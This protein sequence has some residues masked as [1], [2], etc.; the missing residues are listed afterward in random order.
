MLKFISSTDPLTASSYI[1]E[2]ID[3]V[4]YR[5]NRM[6]KTEIKIMASVESWADRRKNL[7]PIAC[8]PTA[9]SV[10]E[11]DVIL[12]RTVKYRREFGVCNNAFVS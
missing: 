6:Q 4:E 7:I 12:C 11:K 5:R 8:R 3:F 2:Y 9:F 10:T 1:Y